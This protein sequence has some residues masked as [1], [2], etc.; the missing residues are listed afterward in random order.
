MN[1]ER[2]IG[3]SKGITIPVIPALADNISTVQKS[4][5]IIVSPETAISSASAQRPYLSLSQGPLPPPDRVGVEDDDQ[6][7]QLIICKGSAQRR[8]S[9]PRAERRS[10]EVPLSA[11][12]S[13]RGARAPPR[14]PQTPPEHGQTPPRPRSPALIAPAGLQRPRRPQM[15]PGPALLIRARPGPALP[16]P[17]RGGAAMS[18]EGNGGGDGHGR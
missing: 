15:T 1:T 18:T 14:H 6:Q 16:T 13:P 12:A 9:G 7:A 17:R 4:K 11:S 2:S 5:K 8:H 3:I 10:P